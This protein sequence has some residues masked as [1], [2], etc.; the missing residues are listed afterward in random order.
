MYVFD[1]QC[2]I[3]LI[4]TKIVWKNQ[5]SGYFYQQILILTPNYKENDAAF[6][7]SVKPADHFG[8]RL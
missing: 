3:Y 8:V 2:V 7:E 5:V 6:V 1:L 4:P